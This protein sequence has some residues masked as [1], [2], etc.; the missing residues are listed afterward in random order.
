MYSLLS[1]KLWSFLLRLGITGLVSILRLSKG[2]QSVC[3]LAMRIRH[4]T[5]VND[6]CDRNHER[7]KDLSAELRSV[8]VTA[9]VAMVAITSVVA[10]PPKPKHHKEERKNRS[11][12][13]T[14]NLVIDF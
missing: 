1:K 2:T 9:V 7:C 4:A 6:D 5:N 12:S 3:A 11:D 14:H 8:G 10:P 13:V